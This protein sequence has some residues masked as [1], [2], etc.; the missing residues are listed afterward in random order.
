MSVLQEAGPLPAAGSALH[1]MLLSAERFIV[2]FHNEYQAGP[3][4][5]RL[6]QVRRQIATTG[7]YWHTTAELEYGARVAWRNS[8]RCIGRLYWQSLRVR[9][10]REITAAPDVASES[11][12]HLREATNGGRIR[13]LIT[14]F[15]P[16]APDR[17][18]PRILSA[19]LVRYAGHENGAGDVIG[20][21]ASTAITCLARKLGWAAA[22]RPG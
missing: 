3:P 20:D 10:R 8:A 2:Q 1:A 16:D 4:D 13:P 22:Q 11:V 5:R 15:A 12:E 18:G 17:P 14:V 21:P 9:D 6:R 19:Q 7:T